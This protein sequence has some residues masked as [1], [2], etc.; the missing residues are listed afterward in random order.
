MAASWKRSLAGRTIPSSAGRI[1]RAEHARGM[2][3]RF[4]CVISANTCGNA[5][6]SNANAPR[7]READGHSSTHSATH[8]THALA[9]VPAGH[10]CTRA[11]YARTSCIY[12][13]RASTPRF[14]F[15]IRSQPGEICT[16]R[17]RNVSRDVRGHSTSEMRGKK[18]WR[19]RGNERF[20]RE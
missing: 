19:M 15:A 8:A 5:C 14:L 2:L 12:A 9:R 1:L 6:P 11:G 3:A 16:V 13:P 10:N 20:I 4:I 18:T 7:E 17:F